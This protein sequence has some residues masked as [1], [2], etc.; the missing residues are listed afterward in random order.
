MNFSIRRVYDRRV[1]L[2]GLLEQSARE[3]RRRGHDKVFLL[4][5]TC[6]FDAVRSCRVIAKSQSLSKVLDERRIDF[7][8][9]DMDFA[10]FS[11]PLTHYLNER[12][13]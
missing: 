8:G 12:R 4:E 10:R 13:C 7:V 1:E 3:L 5:F 2:G 9:N 11:I 6:Q